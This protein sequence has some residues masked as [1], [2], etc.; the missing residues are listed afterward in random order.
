MYTTHCA[1]TICHLY[2]TPRDP[3]NMINAA[4]LAD[5]PL[6]G[7]GD[8]RVG[9]SLQSALIMFIGSLGVPYKYP[10]LLAIEC[11]KASSIMQQFSALLGIEACILSALSEIT[12]LG[13]Y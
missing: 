5:V 3:T 9:Q 4:P 6:S 12:G 8:R 10:T 1:L 2:C 11:A 7:L 13:S